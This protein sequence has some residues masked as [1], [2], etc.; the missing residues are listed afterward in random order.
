MNLEQNREKVMK[1]PKGI[2]IIHEVTQEEL[3]QMLQQAKPN[4]Q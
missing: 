2:H 3:N 1:N 4:Q